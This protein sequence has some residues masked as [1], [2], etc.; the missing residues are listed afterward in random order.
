EKIRTQAEII[1]FA[2]ETLRIESGAVKYQLKHIDKNFAG[3]VKIIY[4][5]SKGGKRIFITGVGKSGLVGRKIAATLSSLG[6]AA[7]FI[8]PTDMLHGDIGM[9]KGGDV[10]VVLSYSGESDELKKIYP[11]MKDLKLK[12]IAMTGSPNSTIA[13]L[14]ACTLDVSVAKE[15]CCYN[16]V[17]TASTTAML[18]VGDAVALAVAQMKGF[19]KDDFARHHPAGAIGKKL[20]LKVGDLMRSGQELPLVG[21]AISVKHS[22]LVMTEKKLGA[23]IVMNKKGKIAGYFTDGDLRRKLQ[24][25]PYLLN[26]KIK[27]VMTKNPRVISPDEMATDVAKM[28]KEYNFDNMPVVDLTGKPVGIIDERDLIASGIFT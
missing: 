11:A 28:F 4:N 22:L 10:V 12:S 6:I 20:T 19:K 7:S 14:S 18:A 15:A 13:R 5:C 24:K 26:R 21:E 9:L 25:D 16:L 2:K 1:N 23:V 17:P 27:E 8:H 3:A